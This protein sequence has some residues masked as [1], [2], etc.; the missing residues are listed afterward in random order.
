M[1]L[2]HSPVAPPST[3]DE[4]DLHRL[5]DGIERLK[6]QHAEQEQQYSLDLSEARAAK[7]AL[8][9][10]ATDLKE[11]L[12]EL[13]QELEAQELASEREKERNEDLT[14]KIARL[15][16]RAEVQA[17]MAAQAERERER[18]RE[19]CARERDTLRAKLESLN[20]TV[21]EKEG[22][23]AELTVRV[24]DLESKLQGL[25][26]SSEEKDL[27]VKRLKESNTRLKASHEKAV[28]EM[29]EKDVKAAQDQTK[30][31]EEAWQQRL[32]TEEVQSE[33]ERS[34][35]EI[36][37]L[38]EDLARTKEE[39]RES[40]KCRL[41]ELVNVSAKL[42]KAGDQVD[43]VSEQLSHMRR[44]LSRI[45]TALVPSS[46][47]ALQLLHSSAADWKQV[48]ADLEES[49]QETAAG[50]DRLK[51]Q[52]VQL[53]HEQH[54]SKEERELLASDLAV[55]RRSRE[56]L[57]QERQQHLLALGDCQARL[58]EESVERAALSRRLQ[59]ALEEVRLHQDFLAR[60]GG[61]ACSGASGVSMVREAAVSGALGGARGREKGGDGGAGAEEQ[62][63]DGDR[64]EGLASPLKVGLREVDA[65]PSTLKSVGHEGPYSPLLSMWSR[66]RHLDEGGEGG[67]GR[68]WGE[69]EAAGRGMAAKA[70]SCRDSFLAPSSPQREG[71][72]C[73]VDFERGDTHQHAV[74]SVPAGGDT[75]RAAR[76][77]LA[78]LRGVCS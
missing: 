73:R 53:R 71:L 75:L 24:S 25:E 13:T 54:K 48:L 9:R 27:E 74:E 65:S 72:A 3:V 15:E 20:T 64:G 57:L 10:R 19:M 33:L 6:A 26:E 50:H 28:R 38:K 2:F 76:Q 66:S 8:K 52:I 68:R 59:L 62:G 43:E 63:G 32:L 22:N 56:D 47:I 36:K 1:S 11:R 51:A 39:H 78:Q 58:S 61:W 17:Q 41:Q 40:D 44:A 67:G 49:A 30:R 69:G 42:A 14:K 34:S 4:K 7:A 21:K 70:P 46:T 12:D 29:E 18:E 31:A 5:L 35:Q 60:T 37:Q 55:A 45:A 16:E 23:I 77:S